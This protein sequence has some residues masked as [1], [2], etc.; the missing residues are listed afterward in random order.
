MNGDVQADLIV[1]V[2]LHAPNVA[3]SRNVR[4]WWVWASSRGLRGLVERYVALTMFAVCLRKSL[5][6]SI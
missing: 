6:T 1:F 4:A 2:H 5:S 3:M